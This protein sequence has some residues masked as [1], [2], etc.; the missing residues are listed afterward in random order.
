MQR[1]N[2][3]FAN[4]PY[5]RYYSSEFCMF[6][7]YAWAGLRSTWHVWFH[8]K[9][10]PSLVIG[11]W[12]HH[13]WEV[14]CYNGWESSS[15]LWPPTITL[16]SGTSWL[17]NGVYRRCVFVIFPGVYRL[18]MALL[19]AMLVLYTVSPLLYRLASSTYCNLNLLSSNF[20]GLLFGE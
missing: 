12:T 10:Y 15:I 18:L 2:F 6:N 17:D 7:S 5:M 4:V 13:E 11:A 8:H 20:Y 1:R 16:T 19:S 3:S 14:E 9:Y